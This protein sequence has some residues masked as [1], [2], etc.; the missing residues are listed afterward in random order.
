MFALR[1]RRKLNLLVI[2]GMVLIAALVLANRPF[3]TTFLVG[4]GVVVAALIIVAVVS[5][6][7]RDKITT[8]SL[9][10]VWVGKPKADTEPQREA[11]AS[12]RYQ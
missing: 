3:S 1:T 12:N 11:A 5:F 7:S 2:V 4:A 9:L 6:A 8:M 10:P